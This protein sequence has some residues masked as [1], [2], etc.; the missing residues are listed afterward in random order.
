MGV[1]L[2]K[3]SLPT[4]SPPDLNSPSPNWPSES[5]P[6]QLTEPSS[7]IT[8]VCHPP[9]EIS[10]AVR[11]SPRLSVSAGV[12]NESSGYV[13]ISPFPNCPHS[14]H[15]QQL[16]LSSSVIAQVNEY[17]AVSDLTFIPEKSSEVVTQP[18]SAVVEINTPIIAAIILP[19]DGN[20]V[21]NLYQFLRYLL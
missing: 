17:P 8:H 13:E 2:G 18:D 5:H 9:D 1:G 3:T 14:F 19:M 20:S 11:P 15:P 21:I 6:Q 7:R 4:P 12:G 16:T 10:T